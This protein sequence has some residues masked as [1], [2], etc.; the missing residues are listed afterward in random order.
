MV[1]ACGIDLAMREG[2][3]VALDDLRDPGAS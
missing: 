2:R 3:V 1:V